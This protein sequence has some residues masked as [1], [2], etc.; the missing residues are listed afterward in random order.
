MGERTSYAPGT[1]SWVDLSTNDQ[2]GAKAF[3]TTLFGWDYEDNPVGEGMVYSMARV[4]GHNVAA[5]YTGD[6]PPHWN[7]YVTVQSADATA[8]RSQEL[9]GT[10]LAEPFDVMDAGRM[11]TLQD[12]QGAVLCVWQ[13]GRNIGATLVNELGALTWN[14]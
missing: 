3:Y 6:G 14:D 4:R 8:Q 5:I 2:D 9:G 12:P 11:A 1:F 10:V 7:C 13:P